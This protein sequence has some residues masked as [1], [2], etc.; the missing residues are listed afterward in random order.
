[1]RADLADLTL[2]DRVFSQHYAQ[3]VVHC[4]QQ[5]TCIRAKAAVD[6]EPII[7]LSRDQSFHVLDI[8]GGWAWG[9]GDAVG[10]VG[11][12]DCSALI[13]A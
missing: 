3:S 6:A 13:A 4:V 2:A 8:S 12:V 9:H 10:T 5:S 7:E 11:Y 1:M